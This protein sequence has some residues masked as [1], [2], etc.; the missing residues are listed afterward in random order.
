MNICLLNLPSAILLSLN[1][2]LIQEI[3]A[4]VAMGHQPMSPMRAAIRAF[5]PTPRK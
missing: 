1:Q 2:N 3:L 4:I 5:L